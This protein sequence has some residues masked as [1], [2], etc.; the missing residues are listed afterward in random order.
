MDTA[1]IGF[2]V[3]LW[4]GGNAGQFPGLHF[5]TACS[6]LFCSRSHSLTWFCNHDQVTG[7]FGSELYDGIYWTME[8]IWNFIV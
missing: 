3:L 6:V 5:L 7:P 4:G 2:H 8:K 1:F